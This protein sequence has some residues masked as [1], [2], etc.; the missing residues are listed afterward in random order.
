MDEYGLSLLMSSKHTDIGEIIKSF[1][2]PRVILRNALCSLLPQRVPHLC[3]NAKTIKLMTASE[4]LS[5]QY[6][7]LK[8][9]AENGAVDEAAA[10]KYIKNFTAGYLSDVPILD[11]SDFRLNF[12]LLAE[13]IVENSRKPLFA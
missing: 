13:R 3:L 1:S 7:Q 2:L 4:R 6:L 11:N 10:Q 12:R 8:A 9:L 5:S